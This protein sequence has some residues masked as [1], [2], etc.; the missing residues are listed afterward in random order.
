MRCK[1]EI[2]TVDSQNT[3]H[4]TIPT[5]MAYCI[6]I[7]LLMVVVHYS[8][9]GCHVNDW[10]VFVQTYFTFQLS[11]FICIM[12]IPEFERILHGLCKQILY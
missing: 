6:V 4:Y 11:V 1:Y 8:D 2:R 10:Q 12:S 3:S 7:A 9:G 5:A